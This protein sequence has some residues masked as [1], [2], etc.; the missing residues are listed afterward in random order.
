MVPLV[1]RFVLRFRICILGSLFGDLEPLGAKVLVGGRLFYPQRAGEGKKGTPP[2]L[3]LG[4][5]A[6]DFCL[7]VDTVSYFLMGRRG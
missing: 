5:G 2:E 1:P 3:S 7:V 6:L 4:T